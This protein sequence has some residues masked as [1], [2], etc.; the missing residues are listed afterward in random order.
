[1]LDALSVI[2]TENSALQARFADKLRVNPR[3]NRQLVSFQANKSKPVYRWFKYKEGF[4]E[5]LVHYLVNTLGI[6]RGMILDPFAGTG[7]TLFTA[8]AC[9]LDS[10]GIE[11]LPVGCEVIAVRQQI[12]G[13]ESELRDVLK[14][15]RTEQ[16]WQDQDANWTYPHLRITGGAFPDA[17]QNALE[18][19]M[20]ATEVEEP[21]AAR[22]LRFAAMCVL[23]EISYTRK[24]GQY[25]RWDFRSARRQGAKPFNKGRILTFDEAISAK[26][27]EIS[28]DLEP[29][30][31]IMP[32]FPVTEQRGDIRVMQGSC[33]DVLPTLQTASFDGLITSPPYANRYD[34]TRT[35]ALELA[36]LGVDEPHL[37]ALRQ[38]M[39]SCTV[40][41]KEKPGLEQAFT[42]ERY[43]R[44][45][46]A[47]EN[48]HELQ[49]ILA[50]LE[51]QRAAKALNN[52]GIPR[53]VRNY[54]F[55]LALVIFECS[56]LLKPGAPF[57]MVNDNVRYG[58][59]TIPVDLILS[60]FAEQ[61]G[62]DVEA[63]WV[64]PTGKG[65]SSQQMGVHGREELR[66]CIYIWR[67]QA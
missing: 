18:R 42:S 49:R 36:M 41:N 27:D 6:E 23:E 54:F 39:V 3:L 37:R 11:L 56:R 38:A 43:Q 9:Q 61:A 47:F 34:Y 55:E 29:H 31:S 51:G 25:L 66:K 32:L 28:A 12:A 67:R 26:L 17:S 57:V 53:M 20:T 40:E 22:L 13:R 33:L 14:R 30:H 59:A 15:W 10:V 63:I 50:Y 24:D 48:Q 35:Y 2:Q 1:M 60:D 16:P 8:S 62:F 7:T 46:S 4:S 19:F 65:N 44:V 52:P 64:L 5:S 58:G 45:V 21:A